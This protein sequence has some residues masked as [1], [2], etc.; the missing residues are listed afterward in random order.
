[1][2]L[3]GFEHLLWGEKEGGG[4]DD[5]HDLKGQGDI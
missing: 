1:M 2:H 4:V 3:W 5:E